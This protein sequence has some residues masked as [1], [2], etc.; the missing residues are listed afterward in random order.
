MKKI[1]ISL[2]T[3]LIT[4]LI[5]LLCLS[6][7]LKD[8]IINTLSKE[9]VSNE[10]SSKI[11]SYIKE[12]N[13]NYD[14]LEIIENNIINSDSVI[15]ITTKYYDSIIDS[16]VNDKEVVAPNIKSDIEII[17][18]ENEK[19][20]EE[21]NVNIT[22][23][24]KEAL[25]NKI[26]GNEELGKIYKTVVN[27]A[28]ENL[29]AEN[30]YII[31]LYYKLLSNEFRIIISVLLCISVLLLIVLKSSLYKW[32]LNVS[33]SL[34]ISGVSI[35]YLIPHVFD[36]VINDMMSGI[37]NYKVNLN[38]LIN[39]GYICLAL[40]GALIIIYFIINKVQSLV[41]SKYDY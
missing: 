24:E 2:L 34:L 14:S 32:L 11:T 35:T 12:Y 38:P 9:I 6:F 7:T 22:D 20:L 41:N 16:V 37:G 28:K 29:S 13:I 1:L 17:F 40:F 21:N 15:N 36:F 39:S 33:I 26:S 4:F 27:D 23:Q 31:N 19:V 3:T 25:I 18:N 30:I 8:V 10:L 5:I